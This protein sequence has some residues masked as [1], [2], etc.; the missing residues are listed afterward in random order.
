[1]NFDVLI[2]RLR[3]IV[4]II[5]HF[6]CFSFDFCIELI[7]SGVF[8]IFCFCDVMNLDVLIFR[9]PRFHGGFNKV[10]L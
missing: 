4:L 3:V 2:F 6:G 1:M 7:L 5:V 10:L 9:F 8:S